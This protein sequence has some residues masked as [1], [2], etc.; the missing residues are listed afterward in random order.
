[1]N[2]PIVILVEPQMGENIGAT[3]RAMSNFGLDRLRI[4]APRDGWP[5]SKAIEMAAHG[6]FILEQAQVFE[7]LSQGLADVQ[8]LVATSAGSR[9]LEKPV[10][11]PLEAT[12]IMRKELAHKHNIA[13]MFGC[14]RSGL[15]NDQLVLADVI[16]TIATSPLNPSL[17]LAQ[18]VAV[19]AYQ[20]SCSV[21]EV[22]PPKPRG[23]RAS[24]VAITQLLSHLEVELEHAGFFKVAE[25][26]K[27]M[28]RNIHNTFIKASL[29]EQ[30]VRT[31]H[32][33][34]NALCDTKNDQKAC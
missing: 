27:R 20:W 28:L 12:A 7:T 14:E 32:G 16:A 5:N 9:E 25:K 26:K 8:Y 2:T 6:A 10:V 23:M 11:T 4:V 22:K 24:K 30:E 31:L 33:V 1:M 19:M 29:T 3:A 13:F 34:I 21:N 17:N 15:S 18:A